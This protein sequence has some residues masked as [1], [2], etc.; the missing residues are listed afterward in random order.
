LPLNMSTDPTSE[1]IL[2]L[3]ILAL[4]ILK[5]LSPEKI[6]SNINVPE[7]NPCSLCSKELFLSIIKKPFTFLPCGHIY[8]R[9]CLEKSIIN[10]IE[11]CPNINCSK[12]F[13]LELEDIDTQKRPSEDTSKVK[14]FS[15]KVKKQVNRE[16]SPILKRLIQELSTND[17]GNTIIPRSE[18]ASE[19][20]T[21]LINFLNFALLKVYPDEPKFVDIYQNYI[22]NKYKQAIEDYFKSSSASILDEEKDSID[23]ELTKKTGKA[24][25]N[26]IDDL[27]PNDHVNSKKPRLTESVNSSILI[28]ADSKINKVD[29]ITDLPNKRED[30]FVHDMLHDLL[31]EIF[32]DPIFELICASSKNRRRNNKENSRG[33]KPDFKLLVNTNDEILFGEVKSPKYKNLSSLVCQDFVK[34][35]NFQS[36]TLDELVK[37]YGNRIGMTS[38]GVLICGKCTGL[39]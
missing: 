30:T 20:N 37:K 22:K 32:R 23:R 16:D 27:L 31:K 15:K 33:K 24:I 8:H 6:V 11:I 36:G 10:S 5:N 3:E 1:N 13:E 25:R 17:P 2:S 21:N 34:L 12:S 4:N 38:F 29:H 39:V 35:A 18:S 19:P 7:L 9:T 28:S 14:L 26:R